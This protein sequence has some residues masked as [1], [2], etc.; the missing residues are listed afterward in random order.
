MNKLFNNIFGL[1]ASLNPT[2]CSMFYRIRQIVSSKNKMDRIGIQKIVH[3]I[4]SD[5]I[6]DSKD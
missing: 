2:T 5:K 3:F 4:E 6:H 1:K